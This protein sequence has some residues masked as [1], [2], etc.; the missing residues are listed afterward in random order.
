[1]EIKGANEI[2]EEPFTFDEMNKQL[3]EGELK[4]HH[5]LYLFMGAQR[6]STFRSS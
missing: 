2:K 4:G 6:K 5:P 3:N 1:M